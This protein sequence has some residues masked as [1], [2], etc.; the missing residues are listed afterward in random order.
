MAKSRAKADPKKAG[1]KPRQSRKAQPYRK[2]G[3]PPAPI[4][5]V[6]N[7]TCGLRRYHGNV[8]AIARH[9]RVDSASVRSFISK[10]P[11]L[12]PVAAEAREV[13]TDV[14]EDMLFKCIR[15]RAAW[16]IRFQL[17]TQGRA[18]GYDNP[19]L[20]PLETL[21]ALLGPELATELRKHLANPA[22]QEPPEN[23]HAAA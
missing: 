10:H 13:T 16:A 1:K 22:H 12:A 8:T 23:P 14:A 7:V 9:L 4:L 6:E 21:L 17:K 19:K 18:R 5:N 15:Q 3:R 20:P 11:E 2:P